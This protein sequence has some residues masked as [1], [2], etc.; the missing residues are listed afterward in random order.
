M[1]D[2]PELLD[3][4]DS[5]GCRE[6]GDVD[7]RDAAERYCLLIE[8]AESFDQETFAIEVEVAL[9][10]LILAALRLPDLPATDVELLER[11]THAEWEARFAAVQRVLGAWDYYWTTDANWDVAAEALLLPVA[12]D[13]ADIWRDLKPGLLALEQGA[14]VDDVRWDWRFGFYSH[15]GR[16]A[17]EALRAI[18]VHVAEAGGPVGGRS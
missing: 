7:M 14:T 5:A 6:N 11:P 3:V 4:C 1:H 15:W 13:L 10:G 12:D 17:T 8:T 9:A 16:H 18:H 2:A